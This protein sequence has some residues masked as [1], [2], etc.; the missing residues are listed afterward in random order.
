MKF[1]CPKCKKHFALSSRLAGKTLKVRCT[2][3]GAAFR[4]KV[5]A[6][7]VAAPAAS[8]APVAPSAPSAEPAPTPTAEQPS[9]VPETAAAK[10]ETAAAKPETPATEPEAV[11]KQAEPAAPPPPLD[12][13][14]GIKYFVVFGKKRLGPMPF[15]ALK[16]LAEEGKIKPE[17]LLWH[18]GMSSWQ[19]ASSQGDLK[20]C[21]AA[22]PPPIPRTPPPLPP[23]LKKAAAA[24]V[25]QPAAQETPEE[26]EATQEEFTDELP[27]EEVEISALDTQF[28]EAGA[29][30]QQARGDDSIELADDDFFPVELAEQQS[31]KGARASLRDFSVMVRL[32]RRNRTKQVVILATLCVILGGT[33]I[34]IFALGD[35]LGVIYDQKKSYDEQ[36]WGGHK[37]L[38][39]EIPT[40]EKEKQAKKNTEKAESGPA[41]KGIDLTDDSDSDKL[42][43][44]MEEG[45]W[46]VTIGDDME[47]DSQAMAAKL[48]GPEKKKYHATHKSTNDKKK[49]NHKVYIPEDPDDGGELSLSEFAAAADKKKSGNVVANAGGKNADLGAVEEMD[50]AMGNLMGNSKKI[51]EKR[52]KTN[53]KEREGDG[54]ALK[55]LVARHV[56]KKVNNSRKK[57][58]RCVQDYGISGSGGALRAVLHFV[59]NGTVRKVTVKGGQPA[60]EKC[61]LAAFSGWRLSIINKKIKIPISV[62][63]Q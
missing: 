58:Q 56:G 34:M 15:T 60:L 4:I 8:P 38:V 7:A 42:L 24:S 3:C 51:Q 2:A 27:S 61:F 26:E 1:N 59:E 39:T 5:P 53:V 36:P 22:P 41:K 49:L 14:A 31:E 33:L 13:H 48:K 40:E 44:A 19:R 16:R 9:P 55:A 28:F 10:A 43:K 46:S 17:T 52:Y 6:K 23:P 37:G 47:V 29:A 11:P 21:F 62:R 63:F 25:E 20:G 54:V 32:S 12:P 45:E 30:A 50:S 18:K 57:L 35:P